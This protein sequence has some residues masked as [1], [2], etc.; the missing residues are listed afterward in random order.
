LPRQLNRIEISK[1]MNERKTNSDSTPSTSEVE[2]ARRVDFQI[3]QTMTSAQPVPQG[4]Q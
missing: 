4:L 3:E 2:Q 1:K